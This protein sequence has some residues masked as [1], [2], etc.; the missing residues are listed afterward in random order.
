[1]RQRGVYLITGGL[2]GIGLAIARHLAAAVQARLVLVTRNVTQERIL[3]V[4][5]LESLGAE[6]LCL[7]A[8][9]ADEAAMRGVVETTHT[10]FGK[11]HGVVHAAGLG[12]AGLLPLK[13]LELAE[14]VLRPKVEGTLILD[15]VLAGEELDF[16]LLSSSM[17][18]VYG[19][20]GSTDYSSANAFQDA[21]AQSGL[22]RSTKR[23]LAINW[24]PWAEVGMAVRHGGLG[25]NAIGT[26]E[27]LDALL[28]ALSSRQRQLFVTPI[29]MSQLLANAAIQ[30]QRWQSE[31]FGSA[32]AADAA[33]AGDAT[34]T[35]GIAPTQQTRP[36]LSTAF[37][38][39]ST[40]REQGLCAIWTDLLGVTPV[41]I[42]DNFFDLGGHSLLATRILARVQGAFQVRLTLRDV[43]DAPTVRSMAARIDGVASSSAAPQT[44]VAAV[45]E[46]EREE[47][48][49]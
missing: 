36:E 9:V 33:T 42:D 14:P 2:G 47:I 46:E 22:A 15:R 10:R 4:P 38:A 44:V 39:P 41:G 49:F 43:F 23:V 6:V 26:A 3:G 40:K 13:T 48:E 20:P 17:N 37:A 29:P 8:D 35:P 27:G 31:Y 45:E 19:F 21:F 16:L 1:L 18:S 28:R 12:S 25:P 32:T 34:G 24:G 11:I 5:E 30:T 7:A